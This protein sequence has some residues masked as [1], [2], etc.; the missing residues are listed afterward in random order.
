MGEIRKV[1]N[2]GKEGG[3]GE[4]RRNWKEGCKW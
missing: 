4:E 3:E 2:G 1:V